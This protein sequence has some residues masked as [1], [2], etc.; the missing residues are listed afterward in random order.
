MKIKTSRLISFLAYLSI[1][2]L[3]ILMVSAAAFNPAR[4]LC[5]N[6]FNLLIG[7]VGA[8]ASV[9]IVIAG[10]KWTASE[11]DPSARKQAKDA[12]LHAMIGMIVLTVAYQAAKM[13]TLPFSTTWCN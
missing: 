10:I 13:I 1:V 3:N 4:F 6:I 7:L 9:V 12:I 8:V 11:N 5:D 2:L